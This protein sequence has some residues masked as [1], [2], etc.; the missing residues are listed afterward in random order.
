VLLAAEP[1][2][3]KYLLCAH[4]ALVLDPYNPRTRVAAR[5]SIVTSVGSLR[6][7]Y[8]MQLTRGDYM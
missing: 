2:I 4:N 8:S 7:C 1:A 3:F 5:V 6:D